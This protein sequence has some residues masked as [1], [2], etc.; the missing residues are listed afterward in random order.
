M[1]D[2]PGSAA[3]A[4]DAERPSRQST[5]VDAIAA[6]VGAVTR[7]IR[8][9]AHAIPGVTLIEAQA[10]AGERFVRRQIKRGLDQ[11]D[12]RS[13]TLSLRRTGRA[14]RRV[15]QIYTPTFRTQP[16]KPR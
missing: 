4:T 6:A 11:L 10:S 1:D 8:R 9:V 15:H 7:E 14:T 13:L 16:W 2:R 12:P 5:E 3:P